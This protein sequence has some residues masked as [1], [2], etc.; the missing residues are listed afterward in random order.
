MSK[1]FLSPIKLAQGAT[2]P[3]TGSTGELFYNTT[4]LK[5]YS[6][7]GTTWLPSAGGF[8]ISDT[9]PTSPAPRHG[10]SWLD[11]SEGALYAYYDDGAGS[12]ARA[13]L[14]SNPSFETDLTGW[15]HS[16]VAMVSRSTSQS[17]S[18]A[19]S[20]FVRYLASQPRYYYTDISVTAGLPYTASAYAKHSA[21]SSTFLVAIDWRD[22]GGSSISEDSGTS[23]A[24]STAGWT[25]ASVTATAPV[26]AVAARVGVYNQSDIYIDAV[27]LEQS[28]TLGDYL[29]GSVAGGSSGQWIQI[30][31]T[32]AINSAL[33]ARAE[34]LES[35]VT[36]LQAQ[37]SGFEAD[38]VSLDSRTDSLETRATAIESRATVLESRTV[39][40]NY[41]INGALDFWQRG[42]GA[43]LGG[44]SSGFPSADR[45]RVISSGASSPA[46]TLS[47]STDVPSGVGAQYSAAMSW[48]SNISAGDVM[49][50]HA[51][52][53]GKYLFAGKTVTVSFYAK[54]ATAIQS[55]FDFDQDYSETF[56]N[57]TTSWARYSH[58]V[59]LPSNYGTSR[60]SAAAQNDNVEMR[61]IRFTSIS[62]AANTIYFTGLQ[63][64]ESPIA[65]P[66]RRNAPSLQAELS[67]CHRYYWRLV[68]TATTVT[69]ALLAIAFSSGG[70]FV[71]MQFPVQM[72]ANASTTLDKSG[73]IKFGNGNMETTPTT[74]SI[75]NNLNGATGCIVRAE[76]GSGLTSGYPY[77]VYLTPGAY[78][79]FSAE[80]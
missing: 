5:V 11:S 49:I 50:V 30:Q 79:G 68:G 2:N 31:T 53:N 17:Y 64:E 22:S 57:L 3:A 47:R 52:E 80:I 38:V 32:S 19:A 44:N 40:P 29:E 61:F 36:T 67:A 70:G 73:T 13:N 27:L 63:V 66:F 14:I 25:R 12:V 21:T 10:D 71:N 15:N 6:H 77:H 45:M 43:T 26:G 62:S 76:G 18:G 55:K 37:T 42:T 48:S 56:F 60:P 39:S 54:A 16:G 65:T 34:A 9:P 78:L 20:A 51:V 75:E 8:T 35:D 69:P 24:V 74:W 1:K 7:N 72:R 23:V 46:I 33:V 28:A 4:D 41:V 59:T 58:T